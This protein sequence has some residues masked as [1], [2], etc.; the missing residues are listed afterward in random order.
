MMSKFNR[1][2]QRLDCER[3]TVWEGLH[4]AEMGSYNQPQNTFGAHL[5]VNHFVQGVKP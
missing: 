5:G 1:I 3:G 4:T 2:V